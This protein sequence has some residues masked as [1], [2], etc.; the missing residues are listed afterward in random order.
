MNTHST[1]RVG[2]P[3]QIPTLD[4][5]SLPGTLVDPKVAPRGT[6]LA[7]PGIGYPRRSLRHIAAYLAQE[8]Y[9]V[10][11]LDYRGMWGAGGK[12]GLRTA[13][14]LTWA[15]MDAVS[16]LRMIQEEY[17]GPHFLLAHSFAGQML[18]LAPEL[19][20][21]EAAATIGTGFGSPQFFDGKMK[22]FVWAS[23][24]VTLPIFSS[25]MGA[26]PR[27]LGI[28]ESLPSGVARQWAE[29]GR[30][31]DWFLSQV[32]QARENFSSFSRPLLCLRATDDDIAPPRAT[33][34]YISQLNPNKVHSH[35]VTPQH[36]ERQHLGHGGLLK[37]YALPWVGPLLH[38]H[39]QPQ[40][41][42]AELEESSSPGPRIAPLLPQAAG[43]SACARQNSRWFGT[44]DAPRQPSGN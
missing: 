43:A 30:A 35:V 21:V 15:Q 1:S 33:E 17:A 3:I 2:R 13:S 39:F 32:P 8:G 28:G 9:R 26:T 23:W 7:L 44:L 4:G 38:R 6:V 34:A 20:E 14:L 10:L 22:A 42:K 29:W 27:W 40:D 41:S 16:A 5:V 11:S 18:G 31:D 25:L 19:G 12:R 37:P 24:H 36:F